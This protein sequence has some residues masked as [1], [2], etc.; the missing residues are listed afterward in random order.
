M[1]VSDLINHLKQFPPGAVVVRNTS[2]NG[3]R[4]DPIDSGRFSPVTL[5]AE[6]DPYG[7]VYYRRPDGDADI[8]STLDGFEI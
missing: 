2:F 8:G 6:T 7:K 4:F 3:L 5:V 1:K